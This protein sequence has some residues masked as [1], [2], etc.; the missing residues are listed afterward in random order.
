MRGVVDEVIATTRSLDG[1]V[2][3]SQ[4]SEGAGGA[5]AS[6]Q[7][8]IPTRNLDTALDRMTELADVDSLNETATDI[9]KPVISAEDELRDAEA[10]RRELLQA[11]GN[12]STEAEA[13][14]LTLKIA[15]ARREIARAEAAYERLTRKARLSELAVTVRSDPGASNE[16]TLGDW[17]DDAVGVLETIAGVLLIALA[18]VVPVGLLA[19]LVAVVTARVRRRRRERA[20]DD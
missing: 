2:A 17:L 16:R 1:I 9:T 3:S 6:L 12:A 10:R 7:L 13:D 14:A 8:T 15:D 5:S 19:V 20:L 4:I 11:L 18:I